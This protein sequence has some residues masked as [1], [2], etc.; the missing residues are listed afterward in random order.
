M[1][2]RCSAGAWRRRRRPDTLKVLDLTADDSFRGTAASLRSAL[3][4]NLKLQI[5]DV[6]RDEL[7]AQQGHLLQAVTASSHQL[8]GS[9]MQLLWAG[10]H[11]PIASFTATAQL[12]IQ[13]SESN[14]PRYAA[15]S[16]PFLETNQLARGASRD[17]TCV[18]HAPCYTMRTVAR[19]PRVAP[20]CALTRNA[21]PRGPI[22]CRPGRLRTGRLQALSELARAGAWELLG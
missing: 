13:S 17:T 3:A 5:C 11:P 1:L 12:T 21:A 20:L 16:F 10:L 2:R 18:A 19:P 4:R 22:C 14:L 9:S 7:H 8:V 6:A 15:R